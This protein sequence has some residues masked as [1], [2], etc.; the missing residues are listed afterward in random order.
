MAWGTETSEDLIRILLSL[1]SQ[2][3][4]L[5]FD[6]K[7]KKETRKLKIINKL[8]KKIIANKKKQFRSFTWVIKVKISHFCFL[9]F[10]FAK[11]SV[12]AVLTDNN[13]PS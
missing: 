2:K 9:S 12:K 13:N 8:T 5:D 4:A 6:V 11:F 7:L 1:A 3:T 10:I